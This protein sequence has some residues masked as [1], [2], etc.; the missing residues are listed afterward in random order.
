MDLR[1]GIDLGTTFCCMAY[2]DESGTPKII[3]NAEGELTTPSVI[4]FDGQK[5]MVG[6]KANEAKFNFAQEMYIREFV[7]RRMGEPP[8]SLTS[9]QFDGYFYG[10]GGMSALILITHFP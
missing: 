1:I 3:P 8:E 7:K 9:Y 2:I 6:K 4:Y 5:A 10:A